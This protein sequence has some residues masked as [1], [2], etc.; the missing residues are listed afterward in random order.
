[1]KALGRTLPCG[2]TTIHHPQEHGVIR[3]VCR[4]C[5]RAFQGVLH[6]SEASEIVGREVVR[7]EWTEVT[8]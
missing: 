7:V 1:M 4:T 5:R 3:R 8:R 2:H 6:R